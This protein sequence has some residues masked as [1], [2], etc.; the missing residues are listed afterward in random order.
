MHANFDHQHLEY[1]VLRPWVGRT[2]A[3]NVTHREYDAMFNFELFDPT[4]VTPPTGY[5]DDRCV[6][7]RNGAL[8]NPNSMYTAHLLPES[9]RGPDSGQPWYIEHIGMTK[10]GV[11]KTV[12]S[13]MSGK[14]P[15][16]V[17]AVKLIMSNPEYYNLPREVQEPFESLLTSQGNP[18]CRAVI[19][20]IIRSHKLV[21][22]AVLMGRELDLYYEHVMSEHREEEDFWRNSETAVIQAF[23]CNP[24]VPADTIAACLEYE[25]CHNLHDKKKLNVSDLSNNP[26]LGWVFEKYC[27]GSFNRVLRSANAVTYDYAGI[28][29]RKSMLHEEL[30]EAVAKRMYHPSRIEQWV[31]R[32]G[33]SEDM[34]LEAFDSWN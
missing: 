26:H 24:W 12:A 5:R 2:G 28:A 30:Y 16:Y 9:L 11:E 17:G 1:I 33:A 23:S 19:S 15:G 34:D 20:A 31:T 10:D 4:L 21:A 6:V 13:I 27:Q 18:R 32:D 22:Q 14:E 29:D 8:V 3:M 7:L 25:S